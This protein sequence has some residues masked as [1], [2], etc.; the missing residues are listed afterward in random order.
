MFCVCMCVCEVRYFNNESKSN[1]TYAYD[2]K[3]NNF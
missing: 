1:S 3:N 2:L